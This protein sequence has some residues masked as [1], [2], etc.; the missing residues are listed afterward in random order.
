MSSSI[1]AWTTP[2][3]PPVIV[4]AI[5]PDGGAVRRPALQPG[6]DLR[7]MDAAT[8][9]DADPRRASGRPT[10]EGVR[11]KA[12]TPF[13]L[14]CLAERTGGA[15]LEANLALLDANARLAGE[16]ALAAAGSDRAGAV[17]R[18]T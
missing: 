9:A 14:S 10:R 4:R 1:G 18:V 8:V 17:R 5:G 13:L 2:A 6:S 15:S 16:V 7:A 11:G 3:G 12:V